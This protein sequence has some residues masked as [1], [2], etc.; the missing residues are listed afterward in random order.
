MITL[1]SSIILLGVLIT[2]HELGH[3]IVAKLSGVKVEVFSIGFGNAL[4]RKQIG[5]TEY[6]ISALP[7]GGYVRMAGQDPDEQVVDSDRGLLNRPPW[8]RIL[9]AAAG[10]AMNLLLPFLILAPLFALSERYEEVPGNSVGAVDRGLPA[11]R[12]GLR[13][14][15]II[16]AIDG[17]PIYAF[18][19]I[20]E[21]IE[22]FDPAQGSLNLNLKRQG[23]PLELKISPEAVKH[24]NP[25]MGFSSTDYRIGY[26]P[27]FL[28]AD[29]AIVEPGGSFARA[30][31]RSFDRV[32]EINGQACPRY[33]D[34][35]QALK[36]L[37]PG[38][39]IPLLIERA[40][41]LKPELP[42]LL[43]RER[44]RLLL[45]PG[46]EPGIRHAGACISDVDPE[47]PAAA[48]LKVGD[49]LLAVDGQEH[50][51]AAFIS[52]RLGNDPGQEKRLQVLRDGIELELPFKQEQLIF[53][54][55][56]AGEIKRWRAGIRLHQWPD[57][58]VSLE[59]VSNE[60]RLNHAWYQ[61]KSQV[62][63][64]L[65]GTLQGLAGMFSGE[66]SP[67]QLSGPVTIFYLAGEHARA[68]L[69]HF[70]RLMVLLS[71]SIALLNLLPIPG[72]DGGQ[73]VVAALE[74]I[75]RRPLPERVRYGLQMAGTLLILALILFAL[76]NDMLRMWRLNNAG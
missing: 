25:L 7:L 3:F 58:L 36:A 9:I 73:I 24:T 42:F 45:E 40:R 31:V 43:K 62:S 34:L 6:R 33:F 54:D 26:Q 53:D 61:T 68:G 32:I 56:L 28:A 19:Q 57:S 12:A 67:T 52:N 72:L 2:V 11:A 39:P 10:P 30:G 46:T 15:D 64:D 14:G 66:V 13:E 37:P 5:E 38:P 65:A 27:A 60:E 21:H 59:M 50:S 47:S 20:A 74:G 75:I 35:E 16:E 69:H 29:V 55:P 76:G 70:L 23:E 51:L 71:I 8:I 4:I 22:G 1:L 18:W 41:P 63:D 49:C 44:L 17:E 48:S